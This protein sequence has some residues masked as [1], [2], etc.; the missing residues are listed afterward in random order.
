VKEVLT[1]LLAVGEFVIKKLV[2]SLFGGY[3]QKLIRKASLFATF[4]GRVVC[5]VSKN[6]ITKSLSN[7]Q[8]FS[9]LF[10]SLWDVRTAFH[11]QLSHKRFDVRIMAVMEWKIR[12]VF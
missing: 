11:H 10:S 12:E 2:S 5:T 1:K 9:E 7:C 4:Y 6:F 3:R 8:S